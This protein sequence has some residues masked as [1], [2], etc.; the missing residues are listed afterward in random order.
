MKIHS[1]NLLNVDSL[2]ELFLQEHV[3]F[4]ATIHRIYFQNNDQL[5]IRALTAELNNELRTGCVTYLNKNETMDGLN[6]YLF[7]ITNS[8]CKNR[9]PPQ[10]KKKTEY[11]C[12]GCLFDGKEIPV[13]YVNNIFKCEVCESELNSTNDPKKI[14]FYRTF[15]RHSKPGYHCSD[16]DRFLPHPADESPVIS[17]PYFDCC[18]VGTWSNLKRMYHPTI[19]SNTEKLIID[20]IQDNGVMINDNLV[21]QDVDTISKMEMKENLENR[22]KFLQ[23]VIDYQSGNVPYSSSD[24]T[25]K[26]KLL[27]YKAFDNLLQSNQEEMVGYLL[28]QSRSGGFQHRVFQEY[29]RLLEACLPYNIKKGNKLYKI[30]SL[31]DNSLCLF[32]GISVFTAIVNDKYEIKNNTQEYYI[33]GRKASY[34][35]PFYMGKLLNVLDNK[36]NATIMNNVIEYSFS[37]IK[38]K[39]IDPGTEVT[40]THL[41]IPPHYQMGGMVYV[42]RVRKKIVDRANFI[43]NKNI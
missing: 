5:S 2:I 19:R 31:L 35:K 7:Y 34:S 18:F 40:V 42:N 13:S 39:N 30:E 38:I 6:P 37:K 9:A 32:D 16:C 36:N 27:V 4:I 20:I 12:P 14:L 17:C 24:F 25:V 41:R 3:S 10:I 22:V 29:I 43:L 33:G 28:D 21:S 23:E 1:N 8:F 26:H 11:I 15:F